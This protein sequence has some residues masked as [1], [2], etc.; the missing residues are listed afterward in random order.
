MLCRC[1]WEPDWAAADAETAGP[2]CS[3]GSQGQLLACDSTLKCGQ[4][5][6]TPEIKYLNLCGIRGD[7]IPS[8]K[9]IKILMPHYPQS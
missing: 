4:G 6:S 2:G 8:C 3:G 7:L 1:L 5:L 9:A